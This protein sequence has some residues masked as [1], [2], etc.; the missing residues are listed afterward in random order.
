MQSAADQ[1]AE[2]K[3]QDQFNAESQQ[4]QKDNA[5]NAAAIG[6]VQSQLNE[7]RVTI[8]RL[9]ADYTNMQASL[10]TANNNVQLQTSTASKLQDQASQLRTSNDALVKQ[11]EEFGR[12][13]AELT[14]TLESLQARQEET[15]EQLAQSK[16]N[17]QKLSARSRSGGMIRTKSWRRRWPM[18]WARPRSTASFATN[19]SSTETPS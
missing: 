6:A 16:E 1:A 19:A 17:N 2:Q 12:R 15:Q 14:S 13:N 5:D 11:N 10:N 7:S 9:Q 18:G 3:A 4:H 8:A